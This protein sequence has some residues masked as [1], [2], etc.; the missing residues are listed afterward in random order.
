MSREL[1][2]GFSLM[3]VL[4]VVIL[5]GILSGLAYSSLVELINTNRAKEAARDITAFAERALAEGQMRKK[6]V[7]ISIDDASKTI[8]AVMGAA[9]EENPVTISRPLAGGFSVSSV[10]G[11]NACTQYTEAV[12][13]VSIGHSSI[14]AGCFVVC[15]N[16]NYCGS[17]VKTPEKNTFTSYIRKRNS[18]DWELLL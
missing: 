18:S 1:K 8:Q 2:K 11:P 10:A 5:I 4:I 7:T 12:S 14:T 6:P 13:R 9:E 16:R 15:N 3:E 17:S